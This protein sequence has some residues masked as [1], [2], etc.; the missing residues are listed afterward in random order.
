MS[1]ARHIT[2]PWFGFSNKLYTTKINTNDLYSYCISNKLFETQ[3][4]KKTD[5]IIVV[6]STREFISYYIK[7]PFFP[8][9]N[10]NKFYFWKLSLT[11]KKHAYHRQLSNVCKKTLNFII[12]SSKN[13][14]TGWCVEVK[15][16]FMYNFKL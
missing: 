6:L 13:G 3:D 10:S 4:T 15:V 14:L 11:T 5:L 12:Q 9:Q 2:K 8:G 1:N 16:V 7:P